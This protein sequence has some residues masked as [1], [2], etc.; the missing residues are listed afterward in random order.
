MDNIN[1]LVAASVDLENEDTMEGKFLVFNI[2]EEDYGIPI[3]DVTEIIGIQ[4]VTELPETPSY[5][6]GVINLRG[7]VI[8]VIDVRSRFGMAE[9]AHDDRTCIVVVT[10]Q[11]VPVGLIVDSVAEVLDIPDASVE[12]PPKV[13]RGSGSR[14]ISGLGKDGDNVKILI[15]THKLLFEEELALLSGQAE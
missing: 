1:A 5:V 4:R 7:K 6:K 13:N 15:D 10:M 11:N 14:Y 2:G 8:P 3:R 9:R 12:P